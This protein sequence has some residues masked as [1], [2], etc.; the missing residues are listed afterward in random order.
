MMPRR[1]LPG[2]RDREERGLLIEAT[3]KGDRHWHLR[4]IRVGGVLEA[5]WKDD[6][7]VS[8]QVRGD[9][10]RATRWSDDDIDRFHF[11]MARARTRL[12][13]R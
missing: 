4:S 10:L 11:C 3:E 6:R 1:I 13:M 5:T 9:E 7:W 2:L 8:G 12:A